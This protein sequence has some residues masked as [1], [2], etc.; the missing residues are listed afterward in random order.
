MV[1]LLIADVLADRFNLRSAYG[2]RGVTVL[3]SKFGEG[4]V[5][6]MEPFG[7]VCLD[8]AK[9]VGDRDLRRKNGKNVDVVVRAVDFDT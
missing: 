5:G 8:R 7:G 4:G 6:F 1:I 9:R 3:P 2:K